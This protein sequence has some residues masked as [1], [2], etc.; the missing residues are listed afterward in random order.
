[1]R[2]S[3]DRNLFIKIRDE[4]GYI[5]IGMPYVKVTGKNEDGH[6]FTF[7]AREDAYQL[8]TTYGIGEDDF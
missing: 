3:E 8:Y 2:T 4:E 7:R 5:F 6:M 1:M